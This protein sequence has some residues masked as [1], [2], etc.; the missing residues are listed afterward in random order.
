METSGNMQRLI[1]L[2][3]IAENSFEAMIDNT[4]I[5]HQEFWRSQKDGFMVGWIYGMDH[6]EGDECQCLGCRGLTK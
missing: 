3:A 6:S 4:P 2:S 1:D 5:E